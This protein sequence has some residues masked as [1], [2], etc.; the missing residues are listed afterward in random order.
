MHRRA[1]R[2]NGKAALGMAPQ[3]KGNA[4]RGMALVIK[5]PH[6]VEIVIDNN[7]PKV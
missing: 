7:P 5:A 3:R 1:E 4:Q 6:A 2:S